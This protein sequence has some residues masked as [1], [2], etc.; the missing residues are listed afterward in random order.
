MRTLLTYTVIG[1]ALLGFSG[2]K[3]KVESS[4]NAAL[5]SKATAL[6]NQAATVRKD[7]KVDAVDQ[8]RQANLDADAVKAA[9][10]AHAEVEKKAAE[11][12]A[13]NV[14]QT[15]EQAAKALEE[16]AKET[17]DL[18]SPTPTATATP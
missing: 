5:E 1:A 18:K 15:G 16:R 14:R 13:V 6:D 11:Q 8:S 10:N 9:A 2:C 17:R 4:Q 3:P 12:S 7:S